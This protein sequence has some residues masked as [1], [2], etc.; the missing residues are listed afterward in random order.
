MAA[1]GRWSE[2]WRLAC[3]AQACGGSAQFPFAIRPV[4]ENVRGMKPKIAK[5]SRAAGP[6]W[7]DFIHSDPRVLLGKPVVR[8]TRLS[9]DFI[10]RLLGNGWTPE[11]VLEN[12]PR[13]TPAALQAVFAY[14]G[15][16]M[17]EEAL[18]DVPALASAGAGR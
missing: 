1:M 3:G 18:Y 2:L 17:G 16:R 6:D 4:V 15:E 7:R 10:L 11:Q 5:T 9:V 8:G 12:Y 14:A 13:L